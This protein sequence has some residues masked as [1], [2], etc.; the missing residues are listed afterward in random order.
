MTDCRIRELIQD[1]LANGRYWSE[2]FRKI[3]EIH[4]P[5]ARG[6]S[7]LLKIVCRECAIGRGGFLI[8]FHWNNGRSKTMADAMLNEKIAGRLS[9][10]PKPADKG[11]R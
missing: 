5:D 10:K 7:Q 9:L 11:V 6:Q 2:I 4:P 3:L 8:I 1:G